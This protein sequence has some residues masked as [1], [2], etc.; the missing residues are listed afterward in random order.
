MVEIMEDVTVCCGDSVEVL[1]QYADNCVDSLV[2]DPPSGTNMIVPFQKSGDASR[3]VGFDSPLGK[4]RYNFK[5]SAKVNL[6][7]RECFQRDVWPVF[8]E[9]ARLLKPGGYGIFWGLQRSLHWLAWGLEEAGLSVLD[10]LTFETGAKRLKSPF[11]AGKSTQLVRKTEMWILARKP[12]ET[13]A[14]GT[15][16]KWGTGYMNIGLPEGKKLT[17]L[18]ELKQAKRVTKHPTEK[19]VVQMRKL[20]RLVT[21]QDGLVLDPFMGSGATGVAAALE[22]RRFLGVERDEQWCEEARARIASAVP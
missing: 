2:T 3:Y 12:G 22:G 18:W 20:V 8:T 9:S 11:K 19:S 15:E 7:L 5:T 17:N 6:R 21:P 13:T 10:V 16:E 1:R 4:L 14:T